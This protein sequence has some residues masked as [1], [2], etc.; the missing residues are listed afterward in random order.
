MR[1]EGFAVATDEL[2]CAAKVKYI[3]PYYSRVSFTILPLWKPM[4]CIGYVVWGKLAVPFLLGRGELY[5]N[6]LEFGISIIGDTLV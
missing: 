5:E 1:V 6:C 2:S 3:I 4:Y